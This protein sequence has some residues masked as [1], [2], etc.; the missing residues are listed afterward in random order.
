MAIGDSEEAIAEKQEESPTERRVRE[1][2]LLQWGEEMH[3]VRIAG[4]VLLVA[5]KSEPQDN[6]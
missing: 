2:R 6:S 4:R 5:V 1:L 3:G